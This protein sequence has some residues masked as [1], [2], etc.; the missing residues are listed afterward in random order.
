MWP[1]LQRKVTPPFRAPT[2]QQ[3]PTFIPT[4]PT[5]RPPPG[6]LRAERG[7]PLEGREGRAGFGRNAAGSGAGLRGPR[8]QVRPVED[9]RPAA[10]PCLSLGGV[11]WSPQ[12]WFASSADKAGLGGPAS[13]SVGGGREEPGLPRPGTLTSRRPL[14]RGNLTCGTVSSPPTAAIHNSTQPRSLGASHRHTRPGPVPG[15]SQPRAVSTAPPSRSLSSY[16][17]QPRAGS[18]VLVRPSSAG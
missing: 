13:C 8:G 7:V 14:H 4:D 6:E 10:S 2:P 17:A 1:Q 5:L 3:Y 15:V 16:P 9:L 11:A 12:P 18:R